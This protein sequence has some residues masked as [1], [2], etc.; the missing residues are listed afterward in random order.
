ML[1]ALIIL[2]SQNLG[3]NP[4]A[5]PQETTSILITFPIMFAQMSAI[6]DLTMEEPHGVKPYDHSNQDKWAT[7]EERL[8]VV[9]VFDFYDP[10]RA[11]EICLVPKKF[12]VSKFIKYTGLKCPFIFSKKVWS[13][14]R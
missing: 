3:A 5:K 11:V 8:K 10:V 13:V 12:R 7:L 14:L 9:E 6:I 4:T 2:D 1:I